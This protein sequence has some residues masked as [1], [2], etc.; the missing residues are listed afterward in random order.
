MG[1]AEQHNLTSSNTQ[2]L[3]ALIA[4]HKAQFRAEGEVTYA[5]RTD[6]LKRL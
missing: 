2:D 5:T 6:R 4:L 3:D 1:A